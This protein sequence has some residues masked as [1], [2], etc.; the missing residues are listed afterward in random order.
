MTHR[1]EIFRA[2]LQ[3]A[4]RALQLLCQESRHD[5][6]TTEPGL[7]AEGSS[8]VGNGDLDVR[9]RHMQGR[10]E[11]EPGQPDRLV[12]DP[13]REGSIRLSF[14][15]DRPRLHRD[16]RQA[17]LPHAQRDNLIGLC[18]ASLNIANRLL[19]DDGNVPLLIKYFWRIGA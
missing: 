4:H 9:W 19:S 3:P 1:D 16:E 14:G 2:V 7:A 10:R 5:L 13:D 12:G 18:K 15:E 6:L 8:H 17:W 11:L